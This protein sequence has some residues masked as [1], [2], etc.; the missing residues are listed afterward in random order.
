MAKIRFFPASLLFHGLIFLSAPLRSQEAQSQEAGP[1][2]RAA[3]LIQ[4]VVALAERELLRP[5]ACPFDLEERARLIGSNPPKISAWMREEMRFEPY[6][7]RLKG[8]RGALMTRAGNALDQALLLSALLEAGGH[9]SRLVEGRLE[10]KEARRLVERFLEQRA[11]PPALLDSVPDAADPPAELFREA[12]APLGIP[13]EEMRALFA[14][15]RRS[16]E[17]LWQEMDE[18]AARES[19]ALSKELERAGASLGEPASRVSERLVERA[20]AHWWVQVE[21]GGQWLDLDPVLEA[22]GLA[23]RHPALEDQA[24]DSLPEALVHRLAVRV[25]LRR[26]AG[27]QEEEATLLEETLPADGFL[28]ETATLNL[29]PAG[30]KALSAAELL[31]RSEADRL[32]HLLSFQRFQ[33][34]LDLGLESRPG[35]VFDLQGNT[36]QVGGDGRIKAAKELAKG[37]GR[38]FGGLAGEEEKEK[39]PESALLGI[40]LELTLSG[41]GVEPLLTRRQVVRPRPDAAGIRLLPPASLDLLVLPH[42]LPPAFVDFL[43]L[44]HLARSQDLL[45]ACCREAE[46]REPLRQRIPSALFQLALHRQRFQARLLAA[47]PETAYLQDRP[48]IF[49]AGGSIRLHEEGDAA[50]I[51]RNCACQTIDLADNPSGILPR[52][53]DGRSAA[54]GALELGV[55]ETVAESLALRG[56]EGFGGMDSAA[57]RLARARLFGKGFEAIDPAQRARVPEVTKR[58]D[59]AAWIAACEPADR[60]L[61]AARAE[62]EREVLAWWSVSGRDGQTVGRVSGGGG[63]A[64]SE[65]SAM[66][67]RISMQL[68]ILNQVWGGM[69]GDKKAANKFLFKCILF[70]A[71]KSAAGTKIKEAAGLG[72]YV[73]WKVATGLAGWADAGVFGGKGG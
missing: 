61:V 46:V 35:L 34:L 12:C 30:G 21:E 38:G 31:E 28:Y 59:D 71:A 66:E 55:F 32:A 51:C 19:Q 58:P 10:E 14:A 13:A 37:L 52:S 20:R 41:P 49:L 26:Q 24:V 17:T 8:P 70:G 56:E 64:L 65:Y 60:W 27:G 16:G 11:A 29:L 3:A 42:A 48:A 33:V 36:Y 40:E 5:G 68:C 7:G 22:V 44:R 72:P 45:I 43:S 50:C 63:Q 73:F 23:D 18:A 39:G 2:D 57:A 15:D 47:R 1:R 54:L 67:T 6:A 9:R 62:N 69:A 53:G 4:R 25:V